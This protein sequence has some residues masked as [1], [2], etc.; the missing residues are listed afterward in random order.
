MRKMLVFLVVW[1]SLLSFASP[2]FAQWPDL[3]A[4]ADVNET[5]A[6]DVAVIVAVED[7]MLLPDVDGAIANANDWEVFF[8][9]SLKVQNVHVVTNQDASREGL[10]KFAK[11]AA[12]DV[13][14][15]GTIW[16]LFIGHGAPTVDG[17]DGLLV[18]MDAQQTVE[19][20]EARSV[21]QAE[22]LAALEAETN[23][24][25]VILDAC[26]SGRSS[27]GEA[28]A[29][30]VQPVIAVDALPRLGNDTIVLSAAKPT[31]VAGRLPGARRPAF[32]YLML[33]AL[34]GWADDG[35][36]NVTAA[37]ALYFA[38]R[39]LRGVKGRQQTP[40]MEGNS[41]RV[42]TEGARES[43]PD[44]EVTE[45]YVEEKR[46]PVTEK[47]AGQSH[48]ERKL[49]YLA[50]RV[51]YDGVAFRQ[52]DRVLEPVPFYHAVDRPDLAAE[53][54]THT[55]WMWISGAL[56]TAGGIALMVWGLTADRDDTGDRDTARWVG[57]FMG[58][59]FTM[60]GGIALFV[61][62]LMLD[63]HPVSIGERESLAAEHNKQ[64]REKF[65]LGPEDDPPV[66]RKSGGFLPG[67]AAAPK[68]TG[69]KLEWR[70]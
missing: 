36:G 28:L 27:E 20:L 40:Q 35:D 52:N 70:F 6:R 32:S 67:F 31:E 26:F 4:P 5:G 14:D 7:Y 43:K 56:L 24:T 41:N 59:F 63:E 65:N 60:G 33:G 49:T 8:R 42:L 58:G 10:L 64:L 22:L 50:R 47:S 23:R 68:Q 48:A 45:E 12:N 18:G 29:A 9:Q 69:I 53:Y 39:E 55:P 19:S 37:E 2:A 30:G 1:G 15:G 11:I 57:G 34:R 13:K 38:R 3:S 44:V 16:W 51:T 46:D 61:V 54:K 25:V 62:G 17:K 21:R 66:Q